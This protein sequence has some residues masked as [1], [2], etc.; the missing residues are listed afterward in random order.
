MH[1]RAVHGDVGT[2]EELNSTR[3]VLWVRRDADRDGRLQFGLGCCTWEAG[4]CHGGAQSFGDL[5]CVCVTCLGEQH[6]KFL[7]A[8]PGG[9]VFCAK[10]F[11]EHASDTA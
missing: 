8:E 2:V 4:S 6:G 5:Q 9:N 11:L 1:L 7:P 3:A 10:L